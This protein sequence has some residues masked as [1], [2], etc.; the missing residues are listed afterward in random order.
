MTMITPSYLGETIEYSSLHACRSTLEDPT[1]NIA[2]QF[3]QFFELT[4]AEKQQALNT[5]SDAERTQMESTLKSFEQLPARQRILCVKNYA[6]FAGMSATERADF[7]RDAD[8]WS[9]MSPAERQT[10]RDLVVQVPLWP[11]IP[12]T[13]LPNF[14]PPSPA[15]KPGRPGVATN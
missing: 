12:R 11:P 14:M 15:P 8:R 3:N 9:K 7:L 10:W 1:V 13:P 2:S 4:P 6:R 5:L